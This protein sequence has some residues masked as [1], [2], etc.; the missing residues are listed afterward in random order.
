MSP[1]AT[2]RLILFDVDATLITTSRAGIRALELAGRELLGEGFTVEGTDFAGRLD[3]LIIADLLRANAHLVPPASAPA[4]AAL[5]DGYA[6]CLERVLADPGTRC[7]PLP[8]VVELLAALRARSPVEVTLGLLTGNFPETGRRKLRACGL[9]AESFHIHVW[10]DDAR[11]SA[12]APPSRDELAHVA[13]ARWA[14]SLTSAGAEAD[15]RSLAP[16]AVVVGDTPHDV[17]CARA[18]GCRCLAVATG[19]Y[20][21]E[22]LCRAGARWVVP[23]L[24]DTAKVLEMLL[25]DPS[26][27]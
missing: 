6:R 3:P 20:S 22:A 8:G 19:V 26:P 12:H 5:R 25:S 24:A 4:A 10:A 27:A 2:G 7:G 9:D 14:R 16:R 17:S 13:L 11:G 15:P 18:A 1:G 23:T 21:E